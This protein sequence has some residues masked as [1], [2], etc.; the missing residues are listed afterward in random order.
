MKTAR[1][2]ADKL[3]ADG[4]SPDMPVAVIENGARPNMRVLR[5]LL[6]GLPDLVEHESV[7][8]PALIVI[9]EVTARTDA[10]ITA[11]ALEAAQ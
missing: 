11:R 7:T 4:L 3:M 5:G 10:Q 2:I 9:G 1:D 6:A 8:S